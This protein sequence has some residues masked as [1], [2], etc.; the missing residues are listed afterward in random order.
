MLVKYD[1]QIYKAEKRVFFMFTLDH[2]IEFVEKFV[3]NFYG[4]DQCKRISRC[5]DGVSVND[6]LRG[7]YYDCNN[8]SPLSNPK[9][10]VLNNDFLIIGEGFAL[11]F[12]V[13]DYNLTQMD[14]TE[15]V[16]IMR[17]I[18]FH[19]KYN[20]MIVFCSAEDEHNRARYAG[21]IGKVEISL[22]G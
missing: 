20:L 15:F 4:I 2:S 9:F 5:V 21:G 10:S 19:K 12:Q 3:S 16:N 8:L 11:E 1:L 22:L 7:K 6:N 14:Y 17:A 18:E 13:H